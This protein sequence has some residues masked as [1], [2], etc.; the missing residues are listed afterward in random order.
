VQLTDFGLAV[1]MED[2]ELIRGG[3]GS[4]GYSAPEICLDSVA[5]DEKVDIFSMGVLLFV[6]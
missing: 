6:M 2:G 1:T 5:Y 4:P 3:A